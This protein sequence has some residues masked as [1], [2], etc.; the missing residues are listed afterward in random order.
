MQILGSCNIQTA[1]CTVWKSARHKWDTHD[2][3]AFENLKKKR[4]KREEEQEKKGTP[5]R[6]HFENL[7]DNKLDTNDAQVFESCKTTTGHASCESVHH[8]AHL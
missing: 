1:M 6:K 3:S 8:F 4:E 5:M 7:Q 2:V